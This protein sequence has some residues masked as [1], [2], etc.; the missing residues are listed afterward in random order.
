[1]IIDEASS[2]NKFSLR[3]IDKLLRDVSPKK[4]SNKCFGNKLIILGGD[5]RQT[6]PIVEGSNDKSSILSNTI[7]YS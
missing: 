2:I 5:Y 1:M 4:Y 6:L 7:K 3:V